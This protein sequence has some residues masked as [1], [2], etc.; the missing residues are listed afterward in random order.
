[1]L[2]CHALVVP[3]GLPL[4][5]VKRYSTGPVT[6][7]PV[8][9]VILIAVSL[10]AAGATAKVAGFGVGGSVSD[11]GGSVVALAGDEAVPTF[12]VGA[13]SRIVTV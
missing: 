3:P 1:M 11:G 8:V 12:G 2:V 4:V 5:S 7:E 6:S 10:S 9:A 13:E